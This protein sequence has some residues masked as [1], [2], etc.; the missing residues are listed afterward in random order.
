MN[1]K[2]LGLLC[3]LCLMTVVHLHAQTRA[4]FYVESGGSIDLI[5]N[6]IINNGDTNLNITTPPYNL[7]Y[8]EDRVFVDAENNFFLCCYSPAVDAGVLTSYTGMY[9]LTDTFRVRGGIIDLGAYEFSV[10]QHSSQKGRAPR[11]E[12]DSS[13][14]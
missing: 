10:I 1:L 6:I 12:M 9:D 2:K 3:L 4:A 8:S 5:N 11:K 13:S 7:T 14:Q